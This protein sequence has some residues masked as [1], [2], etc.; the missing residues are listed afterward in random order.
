LPE[1]PENTDFYIINIVHTQKVNIHMRRI[2]KVFTTMSASLL[3]KNA[4]YENR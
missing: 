4:S 1:S 2:K 3:W